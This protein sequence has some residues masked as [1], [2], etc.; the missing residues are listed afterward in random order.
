M[1]K[2]VGAYRP[3]VRAGDWLVVSGQVGIHE[4]EL[5][6][7]G[8]HGQLDQ[9]IDNLESLL[10]TEGATLAHV[11]KTTVLLRHMGDYDLLNDIWTR[12]FGDTPPARAA[13]AVSEL[14][15]HALVEVEAWAYT[16]A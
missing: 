14:P 9:A 7:G 11:V 2:P 8:F 4:G 10:A 12:R 5:V 6:A 1:T 3:I 15:L 13:F 16:G